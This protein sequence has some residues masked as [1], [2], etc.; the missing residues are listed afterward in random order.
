MQYYTVILMTFNVMFTYL[1]IYVSIPVFIYLNQLKNHIVCE[2][3][4][5]TFLNAP[6]FILYMWNY[7]MSKENQNY[8]AIR[9]F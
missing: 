9:R 2:W 4:Q 3:D 5:V 7:V 1:F 6:L 8:T